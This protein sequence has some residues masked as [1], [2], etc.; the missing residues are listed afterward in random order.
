MM[1]IAL[2]CEVCGGP[3][4]G[5][6]GE[7]CE[8]CEPFRVTDSIDDGTSSPGVRITAIDRGCLPKL[9]LGASAVMAIAGADGAGDGGNRRQRRAKRFGRQS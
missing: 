1:A 7:A 9:L 4:V 3:T 5:A 8:G 2:A 6:V